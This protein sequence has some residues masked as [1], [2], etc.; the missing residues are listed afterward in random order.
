MR[1]KISLKREQTGSDLFDYTS[2]YLKH[3]ADGGL[4]PIEFERQFR[5]SGVPGVYR[6]IV[7]SL[8]Y[9]I[10]L[11]RRNIC[12]IRETIEQTCSPID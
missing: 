8:I 10:F 4:A 1:R 3:D 12:A 6:I 7:D 9:Q 2:S 5:P 11:A